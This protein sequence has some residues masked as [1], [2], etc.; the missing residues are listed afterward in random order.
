MKLYNIIKVIN[1]KV[2]YNR[3]KKRKNILNIYLK[4]ILIYKGS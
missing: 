4:D 2:Y 1:K 3:C